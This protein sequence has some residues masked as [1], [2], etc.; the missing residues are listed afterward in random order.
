MAGEAS[1]DKLT[2]FDIGGLCMAVGGLLLY[3]VREEETDQA[4]RDRL[5]ELEKYEKLKETADVFSLVAMD[6]ADDDDEAPVAYVRRRT[7]TA[8]TGSGGSPR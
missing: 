2:I 6:D 1:Q 3:S 7:T 4:Y 5:F 8:A